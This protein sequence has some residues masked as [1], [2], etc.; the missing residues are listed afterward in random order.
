MVHIKSKHPAYYSKHT[1][2]AHNKNASVSVTNSFIF[3]VIE[4]QLVVVAAAAV[5]VVTLL[6]VYG[7]MSPSSVSLEYSS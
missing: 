4:S 7:S 3:Q 1:T 2:A 6:P 5:V